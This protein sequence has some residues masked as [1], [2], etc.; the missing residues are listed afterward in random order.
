MMMIYSLME[1]DK[2]VQILQFAAFTP[3]VQ[4]HLNYA[5]EWKRSDALI[6]KANL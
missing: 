6:I 1:Y 2:N 5:S 3:L 4:T